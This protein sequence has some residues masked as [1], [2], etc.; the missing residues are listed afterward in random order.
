[1]PTRFERWIRSK[2]CVMTARTP[3]SLVP[4]A[5]QSR[6]LPD[7]YSCPAN[8]SRGMPCAWYFI[9]AS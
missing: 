8:T 4:L 1:M 3:R 7:P 2:L 5:A 6:E 9:A